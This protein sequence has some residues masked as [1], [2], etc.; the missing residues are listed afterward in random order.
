MNRWIFEPNGWENNKVEGELKLHHQDNVRLD[1][2]DQKVSFNIASQS[3]SSYK[4]KINK[5]FF[6]VLS[7]GILWQI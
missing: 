2:G 5:S 4:L 6:Q 3:S 7:V 1:D